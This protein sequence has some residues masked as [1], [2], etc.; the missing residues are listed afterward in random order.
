MNLFKS[1]VFFLSIILY[2]QQASAQKLPS[3]QNTGYFTPG[4][5]KI[6]GKIND[7]GNKFQAYNKQNGIRYLIANNQT[8]L[9]L[10]VQTSDI[11]TIKKIAGNGL[12][13][14]IAPA[15]KQLNNA[16]IITFPAYNRSELHGYL[17]QDTKPDTEDTLSRRLF[18]D[19]VMTAVN[20]KIDATFKSM[21]ITGISTIT[22]SLTSV[23]NLDGI[24]AAA[25]VDNKLT[26]TYEMSVPLKYLKAQLASNKFSYA[27][28]INGIEARENI[29]YIHRDGNAK[30]D[31]I[32]FESNGK[33]Y[34]IGTTNAPD[35]MFNAYSTDFWGQYNIITK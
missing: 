16:V 10:V 14:I 3:V 5:I 28:R 9:Y 30:G 20:R 27:I 1:L 24:K 19:S 18:F 22:D 4:S 17:L 13:L 25:R 12:A 8:N 7:W 29:Q 33:T 35:T 21:S 2:D 31:I 11:P 26:Y 15:K 23:Y 34:L 32:M 6:D